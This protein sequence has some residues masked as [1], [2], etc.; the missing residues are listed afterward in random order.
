MKKILPII[1]AI[2][3]TAFVVTLL[4]KQKLKSDLGIDKINELNQEI[5]RTQ[6]LMS[7][8]QADINQLEKDLKDKNWLLS[9]ETENLSGFTAQR[10]KIQES[11]YYLDKALGRDGSSSSESKASSPKT[12]T[13]N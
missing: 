4:Y 11:L 10:N 2:I 5:T 3:A 6:S 1:L 7:G 9:K 13:W 12:G 8:Y